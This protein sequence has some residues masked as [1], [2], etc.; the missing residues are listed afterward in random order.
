MQKWIIH[1]R[2]KLFYGTD[3]TSQKRSVVFLYPKIKSCTGATP[4]KGVR[5]M[6]V[7]VTH[8]FYDKTADLALRKKDD[9]LEVTK[10][11]A[12][13]LQAMKLVK[14]VETKAKTEN[15]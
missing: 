8:D 5:K 4:E 2:K 15:V 10:E 11:R 6:K 13:F 9:V 7:K 3:T 14:P 12:E 1:Q